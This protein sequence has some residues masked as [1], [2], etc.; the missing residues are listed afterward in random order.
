MKKKMVALLLTAA[1]ALSMTACGNSSQAPSS[2]SNSSQEEGSEAASDK[3]ETASS[4]ETFK[5]GVF[6]PLSGASAAYGQEAKNAIEMAVDYVNE[7][8]GFNG[9]PGEVV[10]YDTQGSVEEAVKV[11]AKL[12][13][14]DKADAMIGSIISSEMFATGNAMNDAGIYSLG[15]GNSA[16]WMEEDWPYVFRAVINSSFVMPEVVG[17]IQELDYK[18]VSA[19]YGQ[20]DASLS[21]LNE[22]QS[23]C[24]EAGIEILVSESYDQGD[25]DFSA[26]V[27][28]IIRSN[29]DCVFTSVLSE[30]APTII[31]QLRQLGYDGMIFN[32]EAVT[33]SQIEVA[34]A[35]NTNHV[36]FSTPYVTYSSVDDIDIEYVK[37][38]C[39]M[40]QDAYGEINQTDCAYRGWDT[41]ITIWEAS[42]VAGSN[43]SEALRDATNT[44]SD[45][46]GLGGTLDFTAGNRE[47]Y[48]KGVN[49]FILQDGKNVLWT[50]WKENGGYD[51]FLSD[52][53]REK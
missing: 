50:D 52:T 25:T 16:S 33:M 19:F 30:S 12:I 39:Q 31:K 27:A 44:I 22:F 32:K 43:D 3:E 9:V 20:D 46:E 51:T 5:I 29:P 41:V 36:A 47:G 18:T 34:G 7:N 10:T 13:N 15:L 4:K 23:S 45:L 28:N 26:Q 24:E 53:G 21:T 1:M 2:D 49:S 48:F 14:E 42:K 11:V 35:E 6:Q 8:G 40:Y 38:F 37:E 17:L